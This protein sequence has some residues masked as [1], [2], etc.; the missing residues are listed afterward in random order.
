MADRL[1]GLTASAAASVQPPTKTARR[2]KSCLLVRG[3]Q[4]VAP[5]DPGAQGPQ[6]LRLVARA[7]G[8]QLE[9][10]GET[11]EQGPRGEDRDA[12]RRQ[13]D[14]QRQPVQPPADLHH[15]RRVLAVDDEPRAD[16]LG[17]VDEQADRAVAVE[18][19]RRRRRPRIGKRQRRDR[20]DVL[21]GDPQQR[22]A[23]HQHR[24][25]GSGAE[26]IDQVRSG[27]QQMLE[28]VEDEQHR[29]RSKVGSQ[30]GSG[31]S[32]RSTGGRRPVRS[33]ATT[34][35][36]SPTEASG[37]NATVSNPASRSDAASMA[38]RVLPTPPGPVRVTSRADGRSSRSPSAAA[39]RSRPT[40]VVNGTGRWPAHSGR[41]SAARAVPARRPFRLSESG[42]AATSTGSPR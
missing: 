35:S 31:S 22:P 30:G 13:L 20:D 11:R 41:R 16:R 33:S 17:A 6:A 9:A 34:S 29:P 3:Q 42:A 18:R 2:R 28:A 4:V 25:A 19:A 14:G 32:R 7:V 39:S 40:I 24:E 38:S 37:T 27:S 15:V 21:A 36:G 23:G 1:D 12:G 26:E 8:Q 5:G 10:T